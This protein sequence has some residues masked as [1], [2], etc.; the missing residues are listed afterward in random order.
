MLSARLLGNQWSF[1]RIKSY[2]W[3]FECAGVSAPNHL[4]VQGSAVYFFSSRAWMCCWSACVILIASASAICNHETKKSNEKSAKSGIKVVLPRPSLGF[5]FDHK[6]VLKH[7][8]HLWEQN[9]ILWWFL[10]SYR[11]VR[12]LY[13][14]N[15]PKWCV[16]LC[17]E[18]AFWKFWKNF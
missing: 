13:E 4:I 16:A 5:L 11:K 14:E 18:P 8:D 2:M 7:Q 6:R 9:N 10:Y 15:T 1:W 3:S 12:K 17:L